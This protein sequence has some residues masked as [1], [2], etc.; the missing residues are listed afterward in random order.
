MCHLQLL[1]DLCRCITLKVTKSWTTIRFNL[2]CQMF[3]AN[4]YEILLSTRLKIKGREGVSGENWLIVQLSN[5]DGFGLEFHEN[6]KPKCLYL[7]TWEC[8]STI[9]YL[10]LQLPLIPSILIGP[11]SSDWEGYMQHFYSDWATIP[12][13]SGISGSMSMLLM[14][15]FLFYFLH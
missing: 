4:K 2:A 15:C 12:I 6:T 7:T 3:Q 5:A 8:N 1:W 9:N 14:S 10:F 13:I 11:V